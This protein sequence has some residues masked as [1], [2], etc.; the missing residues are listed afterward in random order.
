MKLIDADK[1]NA[2]IESAQKAV[3]NSDA[4]VGVIQ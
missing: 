3:E 2:D 4:I 1:L